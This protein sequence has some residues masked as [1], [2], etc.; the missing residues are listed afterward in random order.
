MINLSIYE[1]I[2]KYIDRSPLNT[3]VIVK[4]RSYENALNIGHF[5]KKIKIKRLK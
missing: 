1:S 3:D 5:F 2:I 4:N